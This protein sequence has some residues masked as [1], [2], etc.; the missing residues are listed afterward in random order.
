[1]TIECTECDFAVPTEIH[2]YTIDLESGEVQKLAVDDVI[3]ELPPCV[4][5]GGDM[6]Y[7]EPDE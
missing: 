1:M 2:P 5:C 7:H 4:E 6:E 3:E